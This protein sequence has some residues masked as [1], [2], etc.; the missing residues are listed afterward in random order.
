M[1][2]SKAIAPLTA[3]KNYLGNIETK[4][5][6]EDI[7]KDK[8]AAFMASIVNVCG[9][10]YSL[11]K[12]DPVSIMNSALVAATLDLPIDPNLG[13]AAIVPYGDK[14]Q[15]QMMYKGFV[16]LA[17]RSAEYEGMNVSEVYEDEIQSYNPIT[18]EII[19]ADFATTSQR[20]SGDESKVAGV[21]AWFRMKNGFMKP[22]YMTMDHIEKHANRYSQAYRKDIRNKTKDSI[23]SENRLAMA[24]KTVLKL[25]ISKWGLL[26]VQMQKAVS[27]DQAVIK[28]Y[29]DGEFEIDYDD[30]QPDT[31]T[32]ASK[33]DETGEAVAP[34]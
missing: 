4:Q 11:S 19:F 18:G 2:S 29:K 30:N 31:H 12:C 27:L 32:S 5:R 14:A 3:V 28:N 7:L 10:N 6:F 24:R 26:S 1:E 34:E 20:A 9:S 8:A 16:Q 15:F 33:L 21:Y 17:I 22:L 23:W 13:L 25:L